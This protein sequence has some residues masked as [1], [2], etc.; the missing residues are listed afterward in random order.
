MIENEPNLVPAVILAAGEARRFGKIKQ[1]MPWGRLTVLESVISSAL[2]AGLD[3]IYVVLGANAAL[4]REKIGALP[5]RIL[6][7]LDWPEGQGSSLRM[8][9][10]NLPD[11][12]QGMLTLL[13]DQPQISPNLIRAVAVKGVESG[14]VTRPIIGDRRGHPVYFPKVCLAMLREL[15][16]EQSGRDV[17]RA[18]PNEF[19]PWF[20]ENML[21]DMDT[22]TDYE[23]LKA[24]FRLDG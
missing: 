3:L 7:N 15:K 8:A 24:A 21:L 23:N 10:L 12:A 17:V 18:F 20:D 22:P 1:M 2:T 13:G 11:N 9:A 16:A 5:I 19:L 14:K 4:I 6:I